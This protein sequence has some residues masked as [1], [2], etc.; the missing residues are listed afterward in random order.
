V[1]QALHEDA[2]VGNIKGQPWCMKLPHWVGDINL[3][4][5]F[6]MEHFAQY[7]ELWVLT[8]EVHLQA[9]VDDE[10]T[11][12]LTESG[13]Y[14]AALA[15]KMQFL[16]LVSSNLDKWV[17]N[18]WAPPKVKSNAWI[19]LQNRLWTTNRLEKRGWPNCG[20][21]PLCKQTTQ[22]VNHIFVSC[23]YTIMI[24][25]IGLVSMHLNLGNGGTLQSK[26]VSP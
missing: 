13:Q 1:A 14:S 7:V 22:S 8:R 23:R 2:W 18:A 15:Y 21:C 20:L 6:T 12:K 10:I 5:T 4:Q 24:W 19:A 16:G 3:E 17:W 25:E 9:H 26:N 11:W